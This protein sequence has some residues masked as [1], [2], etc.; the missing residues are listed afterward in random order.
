MG[1]SNETII[2]C[3]RFHV[4]NGD[5]HIHDDNKNLKLQMPV[6]KFKEEIND[7]IK[8]LNKGGVLEI[9]SDNQCSLY[10]MKDNTYHIFLVSNLEAKKE[11]E[12]FL[13][14]QDTQFPAYPTTPMEVNAFD[15]HEKAEEEQNFEGPNR[16]IVGGLRN[17]T[18]Q[19]VLEWT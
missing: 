13:K 15:R 8:I 14:E 7:A 18:Y 16:S 11:L 12:K 4:S 5:V 10:L 17:Y 2:E 3:L 1:G 9:A 6:S 19:Y